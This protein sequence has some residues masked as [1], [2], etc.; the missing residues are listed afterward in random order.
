[1]TTRVWKAGAVD[2]I[3]APYEWT[4]YGAPQAG[5]RLIIGEGTVFLNDASL[6]TA[7]V[8]LSSDGQ[9]T[10]APTLVASGAANVNVVVDQELLSGLSGYSP[11]A[12]G[13]VDVAGAPT[14]HVT[15]IGQ[16][17]TGGHAAVTIDPFSEM[18]GGVTATG[19]D[20]SVVV[21]GSSTSAFENSDSTATNSGS[22]TISADVV[23]VGTFELS[24]YGTMTF[25]QGVS[26]G[27]TITDTG[28]I[29]TIADPKDFHGTLNLS[30]PTGGLDF[31]KISNLLGDSY[32]YKNDVLKILDAG[33]EVFQMKL[34]APD[35][36][37][38]A[39]NSGVVLSPNEP[40][41]AAGI[42]LASHA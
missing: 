36:F 17:V 41:M 30:N 21:T 34:N 23:G 42:Q 31:V 11:N 9:T 39:F 37:T 15:A 5:D 32:T 38:V 25:Q 22:V 6:K 28:G 19:A 26:A 24:N 2:N 40:A 14:V 4:P 3:H 33:K 13:N 12:Y 1:M 20:S 18:R 29:L 10:A 27:Q 35:G 16:R 8:V 7:T